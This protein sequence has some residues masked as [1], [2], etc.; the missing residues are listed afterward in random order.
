VRRRAEQR[1][2]HEK[3]RKPN[4]GGSD[5]V[6]T[7][8]GRSRPELK[9]ALLAAYEEPRLLSD[10]RWAHDRAAATAAAEWHARKLEPAVREPLPTMS[11]DDGDE[12]SGGD[13]GELVLLVAC[14][15]RQ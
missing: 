12:L 13:G 1:A 4:G 8:G 9:A 3:P 5:D 6:L 15:F 14:V 2:R 10:E 11:H 7:R